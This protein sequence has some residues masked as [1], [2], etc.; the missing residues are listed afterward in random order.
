MQVIHGI[1]LTPLYDRIL[2][3]DSPDQW[4]LHPSKQMLINGWDKAGHKKPTNLTLVEMVVL[5]NE[6]F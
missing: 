3:S 6:V 5:C 2:L 4:F 1:D